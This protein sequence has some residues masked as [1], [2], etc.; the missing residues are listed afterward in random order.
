M[1]TIHFQLGRET[2]LCAYELR[3]ILAIHGFAAPTFGGALPHLQLDPGSVGSLIDCCGVLGG[4]IRAIEEIGVFTEDFLFE[5]EG[6]RHFLPQGAWC[7]SALDENLPAERERVRQAVKRLVKTEEGAH[8]REERPKPGQIEISPAR[9][10]ELGF[11][12]SGSEIC[13]WPGKEG[14]VW[15]GVTRWVFDTQEFGDR[16]MKKPFRPQRRGLLPPKLA[17]QMINLGRTS[18]TWRMLDPF[19]GSG[20]TLM[21]GLG[22]GL[23]VAGSDNRDEAI[24]QT[25][26]NLEWF[27][28]K[29]GTESRSQVAFLERIDARQLSTK[30]DPLSFDLVV[31]EGDLGPPIQGR[32]SRK[33]AVEFSAHLEPLYTRAFAEI[34]ILLKPKGRVSLAV[35]FWQ[36]NEGDPIFINLERKLR[37]IGYGP[38]FAEKDFDPFLYRRKDQKVG[39]AI[40]VLESPD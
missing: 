3:N 25:Q 1:T 5:L 39:R 40:H 32:L 14:E 9:V 8:G 37:T 33:A 27:L 13:L 18:A 16:D 34:R 38:V 4:C 21:E 36:P 7:V 35:P 20:V 6:G 11:A 28:P 22:L 29:G 26:K 24:R 17:R 31:G 30:V 10:Q 2:E 15:V 19:C 12:Q 23:Q